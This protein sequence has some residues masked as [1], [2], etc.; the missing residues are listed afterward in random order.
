MMGLINWMATTATG[1]L[2]CLGGV[3]CVV[4][5]SQTGWLRMT[6][7]MWLLLVSAMF[8]A[9]P[10]FRVP[11]CFVRNWLFL[12][13]LSVDAAEFILGWARSYTG[14]E[15]LTQGGGARA[16][17]CPNWVDNQQVAELYGV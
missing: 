11:T 5:Q 15:F 4:V 17:V 2:P 3:Y 10:P 16:L 6:Q 1:Q 9:T 14:L 13:G 12:K 7:G 8:V